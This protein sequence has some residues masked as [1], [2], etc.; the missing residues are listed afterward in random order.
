MMD[1]EDQDHLDDPDD[2]EDMKETLFM[3]KESEAR[4]RF[5]NSGQ[6]RQRSFSRDLRYESNSRQ[7]GYGGP[8]RNGYRD[9]S[10]NSSIFCKSSAVSTE[11]L[12]VYQ[13]QM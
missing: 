2:N 4:Q 9:R 8:G 6:F 10:K 3:G 13:M 1:D 12:S 11:F 7:S 5:R